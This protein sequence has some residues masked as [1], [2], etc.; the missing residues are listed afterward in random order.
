M[1]TKAT[2]SQ[3]RTPVKKQ[4]PPKQTWA[5]LYEEAA[6]YIQREHDLTDDETSLLA[7]ELSVMTALMIEAR[8]IIGM[9]RNDA[10]KTDDR[11]ALALAM[12]LRQAMKK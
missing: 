5:E 7:S 9:E 12:H 8:M 1:T 11:A 3:A 6:D 2:K 4:E 10:A